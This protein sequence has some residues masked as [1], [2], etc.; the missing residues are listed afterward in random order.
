MLVKLRDLSASGIGITHTQA[1]EVGS[2]FIIRLEN[3]GQLKTLLYNVRRC[4]ISGGLCVIGAEL[5]SVLR[6]DQ[7]PKDP[8]AAPTSAVPATGVA[9][10]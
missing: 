6:P 8:A 1:L 10:K 5:A 3:G 7:L 4:D 2:Q 9:A